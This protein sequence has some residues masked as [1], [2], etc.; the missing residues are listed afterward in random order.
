[1]RQGFVILLIALMMGFGI[2][3]G[4]PHARGW[5]GTHLTLIISALLIIAVGLI[6][7]QLALSPR[8]RGLL[9]FAIVFDGYWGAAAGAWA[10]CFGIQGPATGSGAQAAGWPVTV[11]FAV[12]IP[13]LTILPFV[14]A[15]L[16]LHGL[17]GAGTN[18]DA[19]TG[20]SSASKR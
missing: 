3:A 10:T 7:D 14:F 17:R 13:V 1:L 9:R 5:M 16:S 18:A 2:V 11:F 19:G 20:P 6:W 4:G 15:A 8:Q 12:F